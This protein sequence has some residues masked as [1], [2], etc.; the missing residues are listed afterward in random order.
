[1]ADLYKTFNCQYAL[2]TTP[3]MLYIIFIA[4][5]SLTPF[6]CPCMGQ[7]Y[8]SRCQVQTF[9]EFGIAPLAANKLRR[10]RDQRHG[11]GNADDEDIR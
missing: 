8:G 3:H 2:N 11:N 1:M 6:T 4:P 10:T 5:L 7:V 9:S